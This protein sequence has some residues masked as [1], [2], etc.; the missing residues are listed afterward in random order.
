MPGGS[1]AALESPDTSEQPRDL[2]FQPQPRE[3]R[4]FA[5]ACSHYVLNALTR[6]VGRIKRRFFRF[7]PALPRNEIAIAIYSAAAPAGASTRRVA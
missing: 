1:Q 4:E 6:P 5:L 3:S 7:P 2:H